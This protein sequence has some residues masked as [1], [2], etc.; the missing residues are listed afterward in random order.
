M[1]WQIAHDRNVLP[2]EKKLSL[3]YPFK[4]ID[5]KFLEY[6]IRHA[7]KIVAQ[8]EY[9]QQLLDEN[10]HRDAEIIPNFHPKPDNE[11]NKVTPLAVV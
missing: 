2:F 7:K 6:G 8:T 3:S 9:Q 5:R 10:F 1:I 11:I 4:F